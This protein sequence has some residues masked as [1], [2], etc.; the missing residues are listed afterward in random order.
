[1]GSTSGLRSIGF[2]LCRMKL[3]IIAVTA[4]CIFAGALCAQ[5][6]PPPAEGQQQP[7]SEMRKA[8]VWKRFEYVCERNTKVI[9]YL[10]DELA[11]V[12]YADKQYL[13]KQTVSADGNR[14]SDGKVLWWGKG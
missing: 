6:T 5:S 7:R 13:M 1:M 9:V 3:R 14:Y 2:S 8:L 12:R 4:I 10:R 11:K